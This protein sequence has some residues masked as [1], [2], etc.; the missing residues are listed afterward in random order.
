MGTID[1]FI[2]NNDCECPLPYIYKREILRV[3]SVGKKLFTISIR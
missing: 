2:L 3:L 1:V